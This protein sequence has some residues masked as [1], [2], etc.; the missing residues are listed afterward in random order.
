VTSG[1]RGG[2]G[3]WFGVFYAACIIAMSLMTMP[4]AKRL[5]DHQAWL[6]AIEIIGVVLLIVG[7]TRLAG[8]VILLAVYAFA[9]VH[10]VHSGHVPL[11]LILYAGTAVFIAQFRAA[12][13]RGPV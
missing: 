13:G 9:A 5:S 4:H 7:R 12:A 2:D 1:R 10:T 6:P 3:L 11:D 8:L